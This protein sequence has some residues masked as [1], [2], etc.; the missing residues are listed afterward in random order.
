VKS[1]GS[2]AF[3]GFVDLQVNGFRGVDFADPDLTEE[4]FA[5]AC[6][7]VLE[8]GVAAFLPTLITCPVEVCRRN[9]SLIA[10]AMRRSDL[11]GRVLGVHLEGPFISREPGYIGAHPT[12][13]VHFPAPSLLEEMQRWA[14]GAIRLLTM[15]AELPSA[16]E[17]AQCARGLGIAVSVGHSHCTQSDLRRLA[18]AGA[19]ALTHLGNGIP[20]ELPRH[21][22]PIWAGLASDDLTA[23]IIADGHHLPEPVI[24]VILRVKGADR[25]VVVSD[26]CPIA[27]LPPGEHLCFGSRVILEES[28]RVSL[29][30]RDCLAAS[31]N[32]MLEGMNHLA[33]LGILS[34]EELLAVGFLNPMRLIGAD[35][36]QIRS[37]TEVIYDCLESVFIL[38]P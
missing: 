32:T 30:E 7:A 28:G 27:G 16:M 3:P 26:L 36:T 14:D 33:S 20:S 6:H 35:P 12:E 10:R 37:D 11:E 24:R 5:E 2:P 38:R 25:T 34:E 9:L 19:A 31:G 18:E 23:M 8:G 17:L 22:N 15:A 29:P 13:H 1:G 4:R 21:D